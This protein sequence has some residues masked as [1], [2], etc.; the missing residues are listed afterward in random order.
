MLT[1]STKVRKLIFIRF[2]ANYNDPEA[3][4]AYL[5]MQS[6]DINYE[7]EFDFNGYQHQDLIDRNLNMQCFL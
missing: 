7:V 6:R 1:R 5:D 4:L 2:I 3:E